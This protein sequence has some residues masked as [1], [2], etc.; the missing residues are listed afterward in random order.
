MRWN[1]IKTSDLCIAHRRQASNTLHTTSVHREVKR[2]TGRPKTMALL[3]GGWPT[4]RVNVSAVSSTSVDRRHEVIHEQKT[5]NC[6]GSWLTD[7]QQRCALSPWRT[8]LSRLVSSCLNNGI[9]RRRIMPLNSTDS[10]TI[11]NV[12]CSHCRRRLFSD[13]LKS[14][15][16]STKSTRC[17]MT[18]RFR[19]ATSKQGLRIV[20][21][22]T[23]N[24]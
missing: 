10:D 13:V 7:E 2:F 24:L 3:W 4:G 19:S 9:I 12:T 1:V 5:I 21:K 23:T 16:S 20:T 17:T 22:L 6:D 8:V 15:K 18:W 14:I 11:D